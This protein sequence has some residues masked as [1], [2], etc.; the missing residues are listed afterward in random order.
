MTVNLSTW[1]EAIQPRHHKTFAETSKEQRTMDNV[2]YLEDY[3]TGHTR[4]QLGTMKPDNGERFTPTKER[5]I[6]HLG[7]RWIAELS[8]YVAAPPGISNEIII[9]A[10]T[11]FK[12]NQ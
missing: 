11:D 4:Q 1:P 9:A 6:A 7:F 3:R 8:L 2:I 12:D 5:S 10:A